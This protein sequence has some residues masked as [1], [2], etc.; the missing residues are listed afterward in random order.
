MSDKQA[1]TQ[2]VESTSAAEREK[3]AKEFRERNKTRV[4]SFFAD[5][6]AFISKGNI[7]NLAVAVIIGA[8]F[9]AII[10]SL[11]GDILMPVISLI[12]GQDGLKGLEFVLDPGKPDETGVIVGRVVL[13]FGVFLQ[14]IISFLLVAFVVFLI[15]K[16]LVNAEKGI[17]KLSK[18]QKARLKQL[19]KHPELAAEI[20]EEI[21]EAAAPIKVETVEDILKDIRE[22]LNQTQSSSHDSE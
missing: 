8:A 14:S 13:K 5:F 15:I 11:V 21:I 4:T 7:M 16:M 1:K 6:K 19:K 20:P 17:S 18:A 22:L 10:N 3:K 9:T 12:P 2:K